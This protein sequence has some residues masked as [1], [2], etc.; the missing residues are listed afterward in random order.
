MT[1]TSPRL[2]PRLAAAAGDLD[3]P[4]EPVAET[5]RKVCSVADR[6]EL[7]LPGYDTIRLIV[8]ADRRRREEI[9][10]L[11]EPVVADALR[12]RLSVW[13]LDRMIEAS[14]VART[15]PH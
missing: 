8:Q 5:W 12:G 4:S 3:D 9:R 2:D 14:I 13:D 7:P 6:L 15:R 10:R 11:M 1:A